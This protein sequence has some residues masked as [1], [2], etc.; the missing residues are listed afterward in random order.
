VQRIGRCNRRA[1]FSDAEVLWVDVQPKDEKDNLLLPYTKGDLNKAR[2]AI[3]QIADASP[4]SLGKII[5]PEDPVIRPVIRRRDLV[6]LFDTTPDLCGQDLDISRYIRDDQ[7]N[8]VHFFWRNVVD[9]GPSPDEKPPHRDELCRVSIGDAVKF[10][11]TDKVHAWRWNPLT[12]AWER[13]KSARPGVVYLLDQKCGGYSDAFGWTGD[14]KDLPTLHPAGHGTNESYGRDPRSFARYWLEWQSHVDGVCAEML[15]V[16]AALALPDAL[17]ASLLMAARWHDAGKAHPEFQAALR[18]GDPAREG[19]LW[20][21]SASEGRCSR[22]GFRHELASALAWLTEMPADTPD[23]NL[24]AYLIAAHH[25]KVRLSIRSLPD[26]KGDET[27][28]DLLFA[29]GIRDG[30]TLPAIPGL[31]EHLTTLHLSLMQMGEGPRG[32][33]WLARMSALRDELG[34]FRL[35]WLETLLRAA[36]MRTSAAEA[37]RLAPPV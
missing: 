13:A 16:T 33:S 28:P 25:G 29:R 14:A 8:D 6:D 36:D 7:D 21:K 35:A 4:C 5:V 10:F 31:T 11:K 20:A 24:I 12:E 34:P 27:Q 19:A 2:T 37:A 30:E 15:H 17:S 22:P 3:S 1:E 9:I 23:L 18:N 32:P 26:E